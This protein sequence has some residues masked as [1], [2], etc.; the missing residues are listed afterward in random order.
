MK[1]LYLIVFGIVLFLAGFTFQMESYEWARIQVQSPA[2]GNGFTYQ[3]PSEPVYTIDNNKQ[4]T[5]HST[6]Q[7]LAI[8]GIVLVGVAAVTWAWPVRR[9]AVSS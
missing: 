9:V 4:E 1:P 2:D 8:L 5:W 6:G 7:E 3:H